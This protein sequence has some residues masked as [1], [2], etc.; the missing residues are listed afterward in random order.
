MKN[1]KI[2]ACVVT[3][4]RKELLIRNL[5]SLRTQSYPS[6]ILV[7]DNC[8]TDGTY[9]YLIENG[10]KE[11]NNFLYIKSKSNSGGSGGFNQA[12]NYGLTLDYDY[13]WLMDDDGYCLNNHTLSSLIDK[14]EDNNTIYNS[15]VLQSD[16][17]LT[18][19]YK[20]IFNVDLVLKHQ[21]N[22]FIYDHISPFNGTLIS[23]EV[24][25]LAGCPR[26]DFFIYGDETEFILRVLS[27]GVQ[28]NTVISS[29]YFHP[30][31]NPENISI[32][33]LGRR[34]DSTILPPWKLYCF[35]RNYS[36]INKTYISNKENI[37]FGASMYFKQLIIGKNILR[38]FKIIHKARKDA[39][40][41]DF[42]LNIPSTMSSNFK[43]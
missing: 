31:N 24:F 17:K 33:L 12:V 35:V 41:N 26:F 3:Y 19:P 38:N 15:I 39:K 7:L 16:D 21:N 30:I 4:N 40:N 36:Y 10:F 8:S 28:C 34:I 14:I 1:Y 42:S 2:L 6:D 27:K 43:W 9:D 22:G 32:S 18:F 5:N 25:I 23:R 20:G 29:K 13:L 11:N 37:L